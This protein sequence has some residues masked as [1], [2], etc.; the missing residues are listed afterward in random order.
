MLMLSQASTK[1][2]ESANIRSKFISLKVVSSTWVLHFF[3]DFA[4]IDA[5]FGLYCCKCSLHGTH[6]SWLPSITSFALVA[7]RQVREH[8]P[9]FVLWNL[10]M[11]MIHQIFRTVH[12]TS[13]SKQF[14]EVNLKMSLTYFLF[15]CHHMGVIFT[16]LLADCRHSS[17]DL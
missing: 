17:K 5:A 15:L 4:M 13:C 7:R 6:D 10:A 11:L 14:L 8:N 9:S 16:Y 12:S 1:L 2:F 3:N